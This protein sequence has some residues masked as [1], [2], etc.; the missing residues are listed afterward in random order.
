MADNSSDELRTGL[1]TLLFRRDGS[2]V[3]NVLADINIALG[4]QATFQIN[5]HTSDPKAGAGDATEG[6]CDYIGYLKDTA[7]NESSEWL[8][9]GTNLIDNVDILT[10]G[11][12]TSGADDLVTH[13]SIADNTSNALLYSG[14]VQ[15]NINVANGITPRFVAGALSVTFT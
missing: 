9:T 13:A 1:A 3:G 6:V 12:K 7:V 5:L 11:E 15:T 2:L 4:A 10:F 14:A 8:L